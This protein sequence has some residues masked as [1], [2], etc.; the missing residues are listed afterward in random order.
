[1]LHDMLR[2]IGSGCVHSTQELAQELGIST[3][4]V[5]QMTEQLIRQGYLATTSLC[6]HGSCAGCL[7][8]Q[9]CHLWT[10]TE[11]GQG[12]LS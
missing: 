10:L 11:K 2:L 6:G 8:T 7:R 1:M 4:M 9:V 5:A 12:I 3:E